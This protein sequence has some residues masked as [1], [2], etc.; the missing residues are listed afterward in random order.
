VSAVNVSVPSVFFS[1]GSLGLSAARKASAG[2]PLN[3]ACHRAL[4]PA[5]HR[6]RFQSARSRFPVSS[7]GIQSQCST[8]LTAAA[9]TAESVS[10]M[11]LALAQ[12]HSD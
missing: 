11:W 2:Y 5:A 1:A 12:N 3:S 8:M 6:L 4:C 10:R 9:S 7:A